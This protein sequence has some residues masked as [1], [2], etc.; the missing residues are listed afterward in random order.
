MGIISHIIV[1]Q[2]LSPVW[3]WDSMDCSMPSFLVLHCVQSLFRLMSVESMRPSNHLSSVAPFF[4]CPQSFPGSRYLPMSQLFT[5][6]GQSIGASVSLSVLPGILN[7]QGWFPLGLIGLI[8]LL[9]KGLSRDFSSTTF[10]KHQ[11]F[12]AQPSL[13]QLLHLYM[14]PGKTM[15]LTDT[16]ILLWILTFFLHCVVKVFFLFSSL[17]NTTL[18]R[19]K[20]TLQI[21]LLYFIS[22]L[23]NFIIIISN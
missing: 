22:F 13:G 9:S 7:L 2:A 17:F 6:D 15:A 19:V 4:S 20:F 11:L 12:S 1:V 8:S 16:F 3:P 5:F 10:W 21:Y 23:L 14:T 18:F